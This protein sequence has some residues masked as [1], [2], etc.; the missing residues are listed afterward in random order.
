M[1]ILYVHAH[2]EP[3]SFNGVLRDTAVET[4]TGEGHEVR[5]TDLHE[6]QFNPVPGWH[7]FSDQLADDYFNYQDAQLQAQE[8]GSFAPELTLEMEKLLWCDTLILQF[9]L[10][11]YSMPAIMKG[12]VDRV[13]AAGFA[14]G[15]GRW[16]DQGVFRG[17][18]AM[19]TITTGGAATAFTSNGIQGSIENILFPI[20]HGILQFTGFDVLPALVIYGPEYA[21]DESKAIS[22]EAYRQRLLSLESTVA[23]PM[24]LVGDYDEKLQRKG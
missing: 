3:R 23:L 14:Y 10:W 7:D 4:L 12:W 24:I 1:K 5:Q 9:P 2:P 11:W 22:L 21:D 18:R 16:Y 19:L 6:L 20:H 15:G 17:K 8:H 13:F